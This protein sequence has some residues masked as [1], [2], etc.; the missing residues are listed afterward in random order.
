MGTDEKARTVYRDSVNGRFSMP[1][2]RTTWNSSSWAASRLSFR[3]HLFLRSI[4]ESWPLDILGQI[5]DDRRYED[6]LA[7]CVEMS[8]GENH[9]VR[10]LDLATLIELKQGL[11]SEQ[12]QGGFA[13]FA[14]DPEGVSRS[15]E[16]ALTPFP[17]SMNCIL[18]MFRPNPFLF[19]ET[20]KHFLLKTSWSLLITATMTSILR[21]HLFQACRL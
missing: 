10:V 18:L 5:G 21:K 6:L 16:S 4:W 15:K 12:R 13:G 17:P 8:A 11:G 3:A 14:E 20:N 7:N 2:L 19:G 9:P 1:C